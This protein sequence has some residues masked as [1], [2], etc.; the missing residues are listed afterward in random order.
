MHLFFTEVDALPHE[1][2]GIIQVQ[3]LPRAFLA[4]EAHQIIVKYLHSAPKIIVGMQFFRPRLQGANTFHEIKR[5]KLPI[6]HYP[7]IYL[8]GKSNGWD[9]GIAVTY[10]GL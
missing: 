4:A 6:S 3:P 2:V 10:L 1:E 7:N 9:M 8:G 5:V